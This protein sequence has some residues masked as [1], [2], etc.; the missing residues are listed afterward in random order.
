MKPR[1]HL[2]VVSNTPEPPDSSTRIR[3]RRTIPAKD[4]LRYI[5]IP[6]PEDVERPK[7]RGDCANVERPCPFVSCRQNNYLHVR[8]SGAIT[9]S[10]PGVEPSDVPAEWSCALDVAERGGCT[11]DEIAETMGGVSRERVRQI[12]ERALEKLK[13]RRSVQPMREFLVKEPV[14]WMPEDEG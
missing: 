8:D 10:W 6:Y 1:T 13:H 7:T 3:A 14:E 11:L 4:L 2:R 5:P 9:F 12:E